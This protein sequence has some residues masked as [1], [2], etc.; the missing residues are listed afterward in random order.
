MIYISYV[1][2]PSIPEKLLP[3]ITELLNQPH[4]EYGGDFESSRKSY[5][6]QQ[7]YQ[8]RKIS[9]E[10]KKWLIDNLNFEF[11]AIYN[12][13]MD[14]VPPHTDIRNI[15]FNYVMD[16]GGDNIKTTFYEGRP[17]KLSKWDKQIP[18]YEKIVNMEPELR[19]M[20]SIIVESHTWVKLHT[21]KFHSVDGDFQ[22]PRIVLS[23]IPVNDIPKP[24]NDEYS[25]LIENMYKNW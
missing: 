13:F 12:V 15:T 6:I 1:N 3:N 10:L 5:N 7:K 2:L 23:V 18:D 20:E 21:T 9:P 17:L 22:R 4:F 25:I 11:I 24:I 19:I 8:R 14:S 16:T